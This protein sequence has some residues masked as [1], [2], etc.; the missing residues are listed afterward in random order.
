[1]NAAILQAPWR[2]SPR[3]TRWYAGLVLVAA[4]LAATAIGFLAH[5]A[6]WPLLAGGVLA[7]GE[8][9][10]GMF[11]LAPGLLLAVD[12]RQLRMPALQRVAVAG[13][14]L[15]ALVMI[16]LPTAAL[17]LAGGPAADIACVLA[18]AVCGGLLMGLLPRVLC[19]FIGL[20]PMMIRTIGLRL[21]LPD[22]GE[23]GF[24]A[25]ALGAVAAM[26]ALCALCWWRQLRDPEPYRQGWWQPMVLQFRRANRVGGWGG[27]SS[28]L[29]D[30]VQQIRRQ[31]DWLRPMVDVRH[32]GPQRPRYSLR[33]ALGGLF[34]PMTAA[35]RARQ[36]AVA[37]LPGALVMAM[38]LVQAAR[39]RGGGISWA[40]VTDWAGMFAWL[41]GFIGLLVTLLAVMQ[42]HQHWQKHNAE[43]PL[44]ALLPG[45][46]TP[47][48]LRRELLAASLL[49][50]L[51]IQSGVL[52]L[53]L[54]LALRI[55]LGWIAESAVLLTQLASMGVLVAFTLSVV[56]GRP[57]PGWGTGMFCMV[58][59][60]LVSL[61]L[62]LSLMDRTTA[63]GYAPWLAALAA[64][65]AVF[66]LVLGWIGRRGWRG[67]V[68]RRHPF[69]ANPG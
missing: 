29:P 10:A 30:S 47:R 41:G 45:L 54:A 24:V 62:S 38:L 55:H 14:V 48:Q 18:M 19:A 25:L 6:N 60:V 4:I 51:G 2:A 35:G 26:L 3:W 37:V 69:L 59:I 20:L 16:G 63:A 28:G 21:H 31:P 49:P 52:V 34:V 36:L 8:F 58:C 56:G 57:L 46:G 23:P 13:I 32:T 65:W 67:L 27:L 15:P 33:V 44:L 61:S 22:P 43:L 66:L 12:A 11:L 1:M 64:A 7:L 39:R 42:L 17:G 40:L 50:G 5:S 68:Q 9:F 53:L